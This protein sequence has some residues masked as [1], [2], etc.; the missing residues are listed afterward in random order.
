MGLSNIALSSAAAEIRA[1][2]QILT[3]VVAQLQQAGTW[4]GADADRF[5]REWHD[6]VTSRLQSAAGRVE[7]CSLIPLVI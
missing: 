5:Q 7:S 2:E 4:S 6:L 3:S 1:A